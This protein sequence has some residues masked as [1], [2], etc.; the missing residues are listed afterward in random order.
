MSAINSPVILSTPAEVLA[1]LR[2]AEAFV[3]AELK[4]RH[5]S[6][7]SPG[8][9]EADEVADIAEAEDLLKLLRAAIRKVSGGCE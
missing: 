7:E 5:D 8:E 3:D 2:K 6:Y 1:A 4:V 9:M